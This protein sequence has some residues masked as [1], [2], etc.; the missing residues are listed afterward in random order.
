MEK[1]IKTML[2]VHSWHHGNTQKLALAMAQVLG[3]EVRAPAQLGP[4]DLEA[5][6][7][8]GFGSGIDSGSHYAPLLEFAK[9]LPRRENAGAF[10]FST[11]GLPAAFAHGEAFRSQLASNHEALREIL[12]GK[13]YSILGEFSC[14]GF[15]T[16][17]FLKL[18][19]GLNRGR[20]DATDL[21]QARAFALDLSLGPWSQGHFTEARK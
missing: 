8:V 20:P 1:N 15:N 12:H 14:V 5:Y 16:N 13:A 3:A 18:F 19:G 17:S 2:V 6:D 4:K 11:C 9:A 21:E 7:L 10:I